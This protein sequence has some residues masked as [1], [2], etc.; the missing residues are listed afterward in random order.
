MRHKLCALM[1]EV[2]RYFLPWFTISPTPCLTSA[3]PELWPWLP[4]WSQP[5][6]SQDCA[7]P[8][9]PH[10]RGPLPTPQVFQSSEASPS[11]AVRLVSFIA[12]RTR[13]PY[14]TG[15][16]IRM[17]WK[18]LPCRNAMPGTWRVHSTPNP[19]SPLGMWS[20]VACSNMSNSAAA[21]AISEGYQRDKCQSSFWARE[22]L[23][24][25]HIACPSPSFSTSLTMFTYPFTF[26]TLSLSICFTYSLVPTSMP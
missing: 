24:M 11:K 16:Q 25:L 3:S 17:C 1:K 9:S 13:T 4:T 2:E 21:S 14:L 18:H 10:P 19:S 7:S 20:L 22:Q 8:C 6:I 5:G 12:Q 23:R 26:F 15:W